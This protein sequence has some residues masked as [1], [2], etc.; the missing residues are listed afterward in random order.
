VWQACARRELAYLPSL[1]AL[2]LDKE[3]LMPQG[4]RSDVY[5][6]AYGPKRGPISTRSISPTRASGGR[7]NKRP[8]PQYKEREARNRADDSL[9][10][11]V[12]K[13]L[14][15]SLQP[16]GGGG[17]TGLMPGGTTAPLRT[18]Q[19]PIEPVMGNPYKGVEAK[20]NKFHQASAK[21]QQGDIAAA[22]RALKGRADPGAA[23]TGSFNTQAAGMAG[24]LAAVASGL[25]NQA[26]IGFAE[27]EL[28]RR[29]KSA[30]A[31]YESRSAQIKGDAQLAEQMG[32]GGISLS[33]AQAAAAEGLDPAQYANNPMGLAVAIGRARFARRNETSGLP[34]TAWAQAAQYGLRPPNT[35]ETPEEFQW[36]LGQAKAG[37]YGGGGDVVALMQMLNQAGLLK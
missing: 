9:R 14:G 13:A 3:A 10:A 37:S 22:K 36:A 15:A 8:V 4:Y 30:Q 24:E 2:Q 12:L 29:S 28:E 31:L 27:S 21:R 26:R 7:L 16:P 20:I 23:I 35:F 5:A 33:M 19:V 6:R 32:G 34:A 17:P 11:A 1:R 18:P 25:R